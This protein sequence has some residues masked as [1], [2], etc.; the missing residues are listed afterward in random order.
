MQMISNDQFCNNLQAVARSPCN[1]SGSSVVF[2]FW[3]IRDRPGLYELHIYAK[4]F[5]ECTS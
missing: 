4:Y 1:I 3:N 2:L 5:I